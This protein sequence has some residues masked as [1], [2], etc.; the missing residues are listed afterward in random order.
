MNESVSRDISRKA[1]L[2]SDLIIINS[3]VEIG[4]GYESDI[5][6]CAGR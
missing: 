4:L 3:S 5:K 2:S 1:H 6:Q